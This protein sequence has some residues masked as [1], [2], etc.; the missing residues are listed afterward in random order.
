MAK[1]FAGKDSRSQPSMQPC[2][3]H[4]CRM[5]LLP[6]QW[7][8]AEQQGPAPSFLP[9]LSPILHG[10]DGRPHLGR[11]ALRMRAVLV[12]GGEG[13]GQVRV[14]EARDRPHQSHP[15][16]LLAIHIN[17]ES[18]EALHSVEVISAKAVR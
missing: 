6:K 3:T 10:G 16:L 12:P 1:S 18:R 4:E 7:I 5:G 13:S 14:L 8:R 2:C 15:F 11:L 9:Q 17:L